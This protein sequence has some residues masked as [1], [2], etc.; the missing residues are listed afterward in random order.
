[1]THVKGVDMRFLSTYPGTQRTSCMPHYN[2]GR[3][4]C[5]VAFQCKHQMVAMSDGGW[6][7]VARAPSGG[8]VC[9]DCSVSRSAASGM[10]SRDSGTRDAVIWYPS[11]AILANTCTQTTG[12]EELSLLRCRR[13]PSYVHWSIGWAQRITWSW[14]LPH[15]R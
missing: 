3:P 13:L 10:R 15:H 11:S 7:R 5:E 2:P 4:A 9:S 12:R 14:D 8:A 1:M 6:C